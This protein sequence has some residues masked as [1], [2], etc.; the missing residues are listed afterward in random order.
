MPQITVTFDGLNDRPYYDDASDPTG[1]F[2]FV[3]FVDK[4]I[5]DGM[6]RQQTMDL[7]A[8]H[9]DSVMR[10]IISEVVDV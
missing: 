9:Y 1:I 4:M 7:V 6:T 5:D 3:K 2:G 8:L 10:R